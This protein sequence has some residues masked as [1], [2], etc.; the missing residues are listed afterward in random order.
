MILGL[1]YLFWIPQPSNSLRFAS[2]KLYTW[3]LLDPLVISYYPSHFASINVAFRGGT[4]AISRWW[5]DSV[6][7]VAITTF[8]CSHNTWLWVALKYVHS[9]HL[10]QFINPFNLNLQRELAWEHI[11]ISTTPLARTCC[12]R[13]HIPKHEMSA[14][15]TNLLTSQLAWLQGRPFPKEEISFP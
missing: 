5:F 2:N 10:V 7:M 1:L 3:G 14:R 4:N 6:I 12:W 8:M 15:I 9:K 11:S 13:K